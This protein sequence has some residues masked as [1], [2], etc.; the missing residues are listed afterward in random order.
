MEN[1]CT[2]EQ[3]MLRKHLHKLEIAA[4]MR[5]TPE[6]HANQ[7]T[8]SLWKGNPYKAYSQATKASAVVQTTMLPVV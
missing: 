4:K 1:P 8:L 5:E 6:V 2:R 3:N 7:A